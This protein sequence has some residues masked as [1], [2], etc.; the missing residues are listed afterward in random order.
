VQEQKDRGIIRDSC[1]PYSS[2]VLLV[3]KTD[4]GVRFCVDFRELNKIVRRD[5]YPLPRIEDSLAALHGKTLFSSLDI[6]TVFWQVPSTERSRKLTAFR[7]PDALME[8][9]RMPMGLCTASGVFSNFID[10]VFAGLKWHI[11]LTYID[12]C[13]VY[14]NTFDEHVEALE[15]DFSRLT[16]HG[17]T[18]NAKKCHFVTTSVRFLGHVVTADG[19]HQDPFKLEAVRE[20]ELPKDKKGLRSILGLFG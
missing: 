19:I 14:S 1:S 8:Y 3:P 6:V 16:V 12:D 20:E 2:T 17:L 11:V 13:L 9:C 7:T 5:V 18:L 4:G 10:E 15:S